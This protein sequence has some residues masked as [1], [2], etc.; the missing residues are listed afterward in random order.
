MQ[1]GQS[2]KKGE[3]TMQKILLKMVAAAAF[4]FYAAVLPHAQAP[5]KVKDNNN[6]KL[7]RITLQFMSPRH[8]TWTPAADNYWIPLD[9]TH[10]RFSVELRGSAPGKL[11]TR[12]EIRQMCPVPETPDI[13]VTREL[14][15]FASK[16]PLDGTDVNVTGGQFHL[17]IQVHPPEGG[18]PHTRPHCFDNPDHLGEGPY[19]AQ[20]STGEGG[21]STLEGND[22]L[23]ATYTQAF[24]TTSAVRFERLRAKEFFTPDSPFIRDR[25]IRN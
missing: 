4:A 22:T 25:R 7:R 11:R 5:V 2:P 19:E 23:H 1:G 9:A 24:E 18:V 17:D 15:F 16:T 14:E 12:L 13:D 8:T 6:Q 21:K 3:L 20:I 10:L